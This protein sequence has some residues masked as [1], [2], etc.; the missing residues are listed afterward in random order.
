MHTNPI[1]QN[2]LTTSQPQ[3]IIHNA[4]ELQQT[5]KYIQTWT[6]DHLKLRQM[7]WICAIYSSAEVSTQSG[8][9]DIFFL[10]SSLDNYQGLVSSH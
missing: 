10:V 9:Q 5:W 3:T 1:S 7:S 2:I 4:P 8:S 6:K